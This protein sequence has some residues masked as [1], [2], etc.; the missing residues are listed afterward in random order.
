MSAKRLSSKGMR[1]NVSSVGS[2]ENL[3]VVSSG[4]KDSAT[5]SV[6]ATAQ[7][8]FSKSCKNE[9][10]NVTQSK[11]KPEVMD[12]SK[13]SKSSGRKTSGI[14][15]SAAPKSGKIDSLPGGRKTTVL[16][17][18]ETAGG[19]SN[20][21]KPDENKPGSLLNNSKQN[22]KL[23]LDVHVNSSQISQQSLG[24]SRRSTGHSEPKLYTSEHPASKKLV[25]R[26]NGINRSTVQRH[27]TKNLASKSKTL[28]SS[29]PRLLRSTSAL[30][31][32]KK[33][34]VKPDATVNVGETPPNTSAPS[35]HSGQVGKSLKQNLESDAVSV[36]AVKPLGKPVTQLTHSASQNAG[37]HGSRVKKISGNFSGQ[38]ADMR[39][40][41]GLELALIGNSNITRCLSVD[42]GIRERIGPRETEH[43]TKNGLEASGRALDFSFTI[44]CLPVSGTVEKLILLQEKKLSTTENSTGEREINF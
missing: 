16:T 20:R 30:F 24:K 35:D 38:E 1:R 10:E 33:S 23:P 22:A 29:L 9:K 14:F 21:L 12:K 4:R 2:A 28:T 8:L 42:S 26:V 25:E 36:G 32:D 34:P 19:P 17:T 27:S 5:N 7:R 44:N 13:E 15:C 31:S 6:T 11:S 18:T 37:S 43:D 41:S 40:D 3:K 39:I